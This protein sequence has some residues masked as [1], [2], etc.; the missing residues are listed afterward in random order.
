MDNPELNKYPLLQEILT[1]KGLELKATYTTP[2]LAQIFDVTSRAIQNRI[3]SGQLTSRDL[4]G[5][6]KCLPQDVEAFLANSKKKASLNTRL[7]TM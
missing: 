5:R 4:P 7:R 2:D 3:A 6:A 1:I